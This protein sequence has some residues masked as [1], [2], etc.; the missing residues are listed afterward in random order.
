VAYAVNKGIIEMFLCILSRFGCAGDLWTIAICT[1][2]WVSETANQAK[3]SKALRALSKKKEFE[4]ALVSAKQDPKFNGHEGAQLLSAIRSVVPGGERICLGC[5]KTVP[6]KDAKNCSR[7]HFAIYC[8]RECQGTFLQIQCE[9]KTM[10][11]SASTV[12]HW[13]EHKKECKKV[14]SKQVKQQA[15][16]QAMKFDAISLD[17]VETLSRYEESPDDIV[18]RYEESLLAEATICGWDIFDC[19]VLLTSLSPPRLMS[20]CPR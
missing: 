15:K 4:D 16:Q 7:C 12:S 5:K 2:D 11:T 6:A 18:S 17:P 8:G 10:L 3:T 19:V 9:P 20:K 14:G 13:K 1:V